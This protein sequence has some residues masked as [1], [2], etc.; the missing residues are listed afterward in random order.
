MQG[1]GLLIAAGLLVLI[2]EA[3][4]RVERGRM[5]RAKYAPL[6][7]EVALVER[8]RVSVSALRAIQACEVHLECEGVERVRTETT[9]TH[10]EGLA[11]E[12]LG[13]VE[14]ALP[15][16]EQAELV[17]R[18]GDLPVLLAEDRAAK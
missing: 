7:R 12:R 16:L 15:P 1:F 13:L 8:L 4:H 18:A 17:Q 14:V 10:V 5:L 9:L 3:A 2:G 6:A 11:V